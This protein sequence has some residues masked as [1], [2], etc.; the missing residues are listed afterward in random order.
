ML[1]VYDRGIRGGRYADHKEKK[2]VFAALSVM[3]D[4]VINPP[5]GAVVSMYRT[6]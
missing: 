2:A 3:V 5:A 4:R 1:G 6:N